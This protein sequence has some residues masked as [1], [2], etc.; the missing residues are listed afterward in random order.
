MCE[1]FA[2]DGKARVGGVLER[3]LEGKPVL[4]KRMDRLRSPARAE[5]HTAATTEAKVHVE[6]V[7]RD[8]GKS[9]A[10]RAAALDGERKYVSIPLFPHWRRKQ[11]DCLL[12]EQA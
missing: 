7:A 4:E 2:G 5:R 9:K 3:G 8:R 12:L 1:E 6:I 11:R 10:L